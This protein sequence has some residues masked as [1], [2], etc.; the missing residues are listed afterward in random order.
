MMKSVIVF[1]TVDG[2]SRFCDKFADSSVGNCVTIVGDVTVD[3]GD[4]GTDDDDCDITDVDDSG[5]MDAKDEGGSVTAVGDVVCS[6]IVDV[7]DEEGDVTDDVIFLE[8]KLLES[9][10]DG[11]VLS[12]YV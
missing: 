9:S 10:D 3:E 6:G 5:I 7:K 2:F 8:S 11:R 12:L 1:Y 4:T